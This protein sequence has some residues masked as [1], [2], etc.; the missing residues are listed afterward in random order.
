MLQYYNGKTRV[1]IVEDEVIVGID[2][3]NTLEKLEYEVI[4]VTRTGE[5]AI[6]LSLQKKPDLVLMDIMLEGEMTGVEAAEK[7]KRRI[8]L[9]IVYLT[10]FAD[11]DTLKKAK[12]T[13]PSGYLLK[14]FEEKRLSSTIETALY[15]FKVEAKLRE[16]E[17]RYRKLIEDSPIAIGIIVGRKIVYANPA[18]FKIFGAESSR[19]LIGKPILDFVHEP[20]LVAFKDKLVKLLL[21]NEKLEIKDEKLV[22][23][24]GEVIDVEFTAVPIKYQNK[25]AV[26]IIIR[27]VTE[28][29]KKEKIQQVTLKIFQSSNITHSLTELYQLIYNSLSEIMSLKNLSISLLNEEDQ[30]LEFP[31]YKDELKPVPKSRRPAKG[32]TEYV[33]N[34]GESTLLN[35]YNIKRLEFSGEIEITGPIPKV[36]LGVPLQIKEKNVGVLIIKDYDNENSITA[37]E[38]EILEFVSFPISRVIERKIDEAER[39]T[40]TERL[41]TLN[42]TKDKFFSIISHDLK[43]P[44]NSILGFT[45]LLKE[46]LGN[47]SREEMQLYINSLYESSRHTYNILNNLLEFSRFKSGTME[48]KP[49]KVF[50][51]GFVERVIDALS[52]NA[53]RKDIKIQNEIDP[54]IKVKADEDMLNSIFQNLITNAVKFTLA[55]GYIKISA[56]REGDFI[57]ITVEDNGIGMNEKMIKNLFKIEEKVSRKGTEK[58]VGTGLGLII[59]KD[60]IDKHSGYIK[61]ESR[62]NQGTKFIFTLPAVN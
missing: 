20:Y 12:V 53:I 2:L 61:V 33:L 29:R 1:L 11:N 31:F 40:F 32:L 28:I 42:A 55:G 47:L 39:E 16:S 4:G 41:K 6:N 27:N 62:F 25:F 9:P 14:P 15:N 21:H 8:D 57:K 38:Q 35:Y 56:A 18:S 19:D 43:S 52:G 37:V 5:E 22:R 3:K 36:W 46:E 50:L 59:I 48:Y 10:A 60:Y 30:I 44:F 45:E 51:Q 34:K 23:L 54:A 7:I 24:D 58:E 17:E 26:Q 49:V 13:E